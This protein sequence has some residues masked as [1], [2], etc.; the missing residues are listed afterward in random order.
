MIVEFVPF[1]F[2]FLFFIL[3]VRSF[4]SMKFF[5]M[6][7]MSFSHNI[8]LNA[9]QPSQPSPSSVKVCCADTVYQYIF[10]SSFNLKWVLSLC[11]PSSRK[12][13][14]FPWLSLEIFLQKWQSVTAIVLR[15]GVIYTFAP[16]PL[17][18]K[19]N[20]RFYSYNKMK[21]K[22]INGSKRLVTLYIRLVRIHIFDGWRIESLPSY[23]IYIHTETR[24]GFFHMYLYEI[25][26][27]HR[28]LCNIL[29]KAP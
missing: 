28:A 5:F 24:C 23:F 21:R 15:I 11:F 25:R 26:T 18:C 13:V 29:R 12:V 27:D 14:V 1:S 10:F 7:K 8:C 16:F 4:N 6:F 3:A 17:W 19:K 2:T 9:A 22:W 20:A